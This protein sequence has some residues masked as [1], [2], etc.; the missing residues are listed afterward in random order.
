MA[1]IPQKIKWAVL[2]ALHIQW[3]RKMESL[4]EADRQQAGYDRQIELIR[5]MSYA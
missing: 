3:L 2:L 4:V 1:V 5:R